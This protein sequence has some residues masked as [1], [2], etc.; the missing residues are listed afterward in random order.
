MPELSQ[1]KRGI[2]QLATL[3]TLLPILAVPIRGF[4]LPGATIAQI[5]LGLTLTGMTGVFAFDMVANWK[6]PWRSVL[7]LSVGGLMVA[8]AVTS[9]YLNGVPFRGGGVESVDAVQPI[10]QTALA[11]V[12]ICFTLSC[13]W[14]RPFFWRIFLLLAIPLYAAL[15]AAWVA[16]GLTMPYLGF[17]LHKNEI[18]SASLAIFFLAVACC[19]GR[20]RTSP[21]FLGAIALMGMSLLILFA[22]DSRSNQLVLLLAM[23]FY[24]G[25]R[26]MQRFDGVRI[27]AFFVLI[28]IA[29]A[30]PKLYLH[31]ESSSTSAAG[32]VGGGGR[33]IY[34]GRNH[35]WKDILQDVPDRP[36]LGYGKRFAKRYRKMER[37][38]FF[39]DSHNLYLGTQ[40]QAGYIGL[41]SLVAFLLMLWY[42]LSIRWDQSYLSKISLCFLAGLIVQQAL[43]CSLIQGGHIASLA[44]I[45]VLGM[46]LSIRMKGPFE[47]D[48]EDEEHLGDEN[49]GEMK[50]TYE[51]SKDPLQ[52]GADQGGQTRR[53]KPDNTFAT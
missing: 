19:L 20:R 14:S 33:S 21:E 46:G 13:D 38:D 9:S 50:H 26:V 37:E 32:T 23:G 18:G 6:I 51:T 2:W 43:E 41:A 30:I 42:Q 48:L 15:C 22:S 1:R 4:P 16:S 10:L 31:M 11:V 27:A 34:N 45:P 5:Y 28:G 35:I 17:G 52:D 12:W 53:S 29:L 24:I 44:Y 40:Y 3:L 49:E 8:S 36:L 47:G 39:L 7:F 25:N